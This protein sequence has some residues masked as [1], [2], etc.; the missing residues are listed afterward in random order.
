[1]IFHIYGTDTYLVREKTEEIKSSFVEKKDKGGLNVIRL[2]A[3][4]VSLDRFS[5]EVLTVPFLSE[6]KLIII[7]G[8]CEDSPA[9][10]KKLREDILA[11]LRQREEKIENNILFVDVFDDE[12]KIPQK[13]VLFNYLKSQKF[14]W[15]LPAPKNSELATWIK[16][17][18]AK[19][20]IKLA[21]AAASDLIL[22]VGNDLLQMENELT[23]LKAYKAGE[24][25]E[26]ED[27]KNLVK[28]KYDNDIFRLTD[29]LANKNRRAALEL[30][31][32][33]LLSGNEPLSLLGSI[34]W[35]FKTLL[36]I[37]SI[38]ET[39]PRETGANISNAT[40][41]HTFVVSKN[42]SAVKKFTLSELIK[43]QNELLEI[44][45]QL[46]SGAKNQELLFDLFIAK[47]C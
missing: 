13:E 46:K 31:S 24:Q 42:M 23:K 37:K 41:L 27:V 40:G 25:I 20:E 5:Q 19:R 1:M 38:L 14:T 35:Q 4:E 29:A 45:T 2:N 22:L 39:N 18:C 11:F 30:V 44:E 21:P 26:V 28:A 12:K 34:N 6:K 9:G 32:H 17:Y 36:K 15:Y 3:E 47:N 43:I 10:R 16:K 33:Q 7:S 8:L